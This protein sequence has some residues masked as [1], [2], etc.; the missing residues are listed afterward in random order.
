VQLAA[1][2]AAA[3]A[4][5]DN[6]CDEQLD[7]SADKCYSSCSGVQLTLCGMQ[8]NSSCTLKD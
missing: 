2:A 8:L 5:N 1:A 7:R 3:A 6:D 4:E